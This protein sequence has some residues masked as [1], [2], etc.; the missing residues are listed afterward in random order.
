[1]KVLF[2][3]ITMS[4]VI[5][6]HNTNTGDVWE[7]RVNLEGHPKEYWTI[8]KTYQGRDG[9]STCLVNEYGGYSL[10]KQGQPR[11]I[12]PFWKKIVSIR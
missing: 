10:Y 4:K 2:G 7:L 3:D 8:V 9:V 12:K 11:Y 1:M 5:S 6:T